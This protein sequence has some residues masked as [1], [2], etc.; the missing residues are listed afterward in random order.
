[1]AEEKFLFGKGVENVN[2]NKYFKG[3]SFLNVLNIPGVVVCNVTFEP[4]CRNNWH[5]HQAGGQILLCTDGHGWYQE[6][7]SAPR[8]LNPGDVVYIAPKVKH[9]HGAVADEWFAHVAIEI[10]AGADEQGGTTWCEE[11]SDEEY[12]ALTK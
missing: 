3:T 2:Y 11:V 9:W 1:M 10:P 7:G 5:I 6:E 4:A 12:A 8:Y